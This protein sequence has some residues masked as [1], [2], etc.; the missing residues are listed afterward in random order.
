MCRETECRD[1]FIHKASLGLLLFIFSQP[2]VCSD[3]MILK[4]SSHLILCD[5]QSQYSWSSLTF[6]LTISGLLLWYSVFLICSNV[7]GFQHI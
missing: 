3:E 1:I 7:W 2:T 5:H 6:D 4:L